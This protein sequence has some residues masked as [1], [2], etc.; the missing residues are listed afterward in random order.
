MCFSKMPSHTQANVAPV[1][2]TAAAYVSPEADSNSPAGAV[3]S[4]RKLLINGAMPATGLQIPNPAAR[5]Y[6][7]PIIG[8][9]G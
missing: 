1:E 2:P 9:R 6:N 8:V 5:N 4:R 3:T 7:A